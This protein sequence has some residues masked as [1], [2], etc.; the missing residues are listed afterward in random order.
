MKTYPLACV[1]G[2]TAGLVFV[3]LACTA[4]M[5]ASL[6]FFAVFTALLFKRLDF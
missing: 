4:G 5:F 3:T 2:L 6:L 1:T